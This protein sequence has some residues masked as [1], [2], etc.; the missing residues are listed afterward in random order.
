MFPPAVDEDFGVG[1]VG[2]EAVAEG[3]EFGSQVAVVI[4]APVKGNGDE[5]GAC[6]EVCGVDGVGGRGCGGFGIESLVRARGVGRWGRPLA[7]ARGSLGC[8]GNRGEQL[9]GAVLV[10]EVDHGLGA[11]CVV[12]DAEAAVDEGDVDG[13]AVVADCPVAESA[14]AVG[15]TVLDGLIEGVEPRLRD[16]FV[17]GWDGFARLVDSQDAAD[18]AHVRRIAGGAVGTRA[19]MR[20]SGPAQTVE[21]GGRG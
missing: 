2:L 7:C 3:F 16:G 10:A 4:D 5:V 18:A 17:V 12:D 8:T 21:E 9:A 13:S 19:S 6:G 14:L 15:A 1:V 11:A 20:P